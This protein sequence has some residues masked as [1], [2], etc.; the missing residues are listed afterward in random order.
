MR[1]NTVRRTTRASAG[2]AI[3]AVAILGL[4]GCFNPVEQL[5]SD[6]IE[7]AI[8]EQL[9]A[10]ID[11]DGGTITIEGEDGESVRLGIGTEIPDTF[12]GFLPLPAEGQLVTSA[13][14]ADGWALHYEGVSEA[15][16]DAMH[17]ALLSAGFTEESVTEIGPL[18][19][20]VL[21]SN[22]YNVMLGWFGDDDMLNYTVART[23]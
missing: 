4:T 9:G 7:R 13:E 10:E 3:A 14:I 22:E 18:R 20:V 15:A 12:P 2:A 17:D 8:E 11:R 23:G 5:V 6:G 19:S 21:G 16:V 1:A